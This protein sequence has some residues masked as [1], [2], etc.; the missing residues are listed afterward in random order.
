M[1]K[2]R[3]AASKSV[4][5]HYIIDYYQQWMMKIIPDTTYLLLELSN[6]VNKLLQTIILK[7]KVWYYIRSWR[8]VRK[9]CISCNVWNIFTSLKFYWKCF[10]IFMKVF[11][12]SD[13]W[14]HHCHHCQ[15]K[16]SP[17][18]MFYY[19]LISFIIFFFA[20]PNCFCN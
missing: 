19:N 1:L 12:P 8:K 16:P 4:L 14:G 18:I 15:N 7:K 10:I 3:V 5:F 17:S 9:D 6:Y 13:N 11:I 20:L 2:V